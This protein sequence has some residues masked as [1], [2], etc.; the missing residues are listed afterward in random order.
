MPDET[1]MSV[2]LQFGSPKDEAN[3]VAMKSKMMD[4]PFEKAPG[5]DSPP[6][7]KA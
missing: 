5:K 2:D 7:K 6:I 4:L 3:A 1:L